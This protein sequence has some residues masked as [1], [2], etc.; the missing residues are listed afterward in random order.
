MGE[1]KRIPA[2]E[3]ATMKYEDTKFKPM[4]RRFGS[5]KRIIT[6]MNFNLSLLLGILFAVIAC[7]FCIIKEVINVICPIFITV[8]ATMIAVAIAGLAIIVSMSDPDFIKIL[9]QAGVYNN[10]LFMFWYS[11]VIS[12]SSIII[13]TLTYIIPYLANRLLI[14]LILL[15]AST[16]LVLYSIFS[17]ILL[18]GTTMRYGLYRGA[19]IEQED[20][21]DA[22]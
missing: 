9:K 1:N 21:K 7:Y 4:F 14:F 15:S 22:D 12:G 6:S 8:S 10:I 16:F 19:F 13:N 11:T 5:I 18:V 3:E 20:N 17:V 2:T